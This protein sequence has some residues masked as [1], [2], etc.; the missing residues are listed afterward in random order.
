MEGNITKNFKAEVRQVL[1]LVIHSL[2]TNRD[3]FLREL[4]SNASD[5][6]DK[7][8]FESLTRPELSAG[9]KIEIALDKKNK[10]I[11]IRDNGI[12]M[13]FAE[14]EENIGTIAKSGTKAFLEKLSGEKNAS[15][16]ELIGQFGVG[17]YSAFMVAEEITIVSKRAGSHETAA[18]WRSRGEDSYELSDDSKKEHGTE[19]TLKLKSSCE[20]YLEDWKIREIIHKYSD[21]IEHP[22]FILS[23][24]NEKDSPPKPVNSMKALWLRKP[25]EITPDEY[26]QF[27]AHISH[28]DKAPL[29]HIHFSAEGTS[30]FKALIYIPSEAPPFFSAPEFGKKDIHLY[31]KRVFI[32][33]SCDGLLPDYLR[34][35]KGVVESDDLPLNISRE[36]LQNNPQIQKINRSLAR[37]ILAEL[38][39]LLENDREKYL[40]FHRNFG[41][42]LREGAN[43]DLQNR[44]KILDLLIFKTIK[45]GKE[46]PL[47]L[48]EIS[49]NMPVKQEKLF[50]AVGE[51][52]DALAQS[53]LVESAKENGFDVI[54]VN[55]PVDEY[56][57]Q[58]CGKYRHREFISLNQ[59]KINIDDNNKL[60][61]KKTAAEKKYSKALKAFK[62]YLGDKVKDVKFSE[63]LV[64]SPCCLVGGQFAPSRQMEKLMRALHNDMPE[65]KRIL[66]LNPSHPMIEKV[67]NG[68]EANPESAEFAKFANLTFNLALLADGEMPPD[69]AGFTSSISELIGKSVKL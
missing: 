9:W 64:S 26:K 39:K 63:R 54:L 44:E 68:F 19:I 18:R 57:F 10:I 49:D 3:I 16:P 52:I 66:E 40:S 62:K 1:D 55:D 67:M 23:P 27:Y 17:F 31:V 12:G 15:T 56:I 29:S 28:F 61:E 7:A 37:K 42:I 36:T 20:E 51:N 60:S 32:T 35:A 69:I 8:R 22:I 33:E 6:I 38:A 34:F 21:F 5:A 25:E 13:T 45:N 46:K 24:E 53:P 11:K 50:Y 48:K 2:Y 4:I 59:D 43:S 41:K 14:I 30:N 47:S 58:A 65:N